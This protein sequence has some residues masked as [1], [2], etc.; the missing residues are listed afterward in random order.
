MNNLE[1]TVKDRMPAIIR[2]FKDSG[3]DAGNAYGASFVD[4]IKDS[5]N[6]FN[7]VVKSATDS[8]QAQLST[9]LKAAND[10]STAI[11]SLTEKV[12]N[13]ELNAVYPNIVME[14]DGRQIAKAAG[15]YMGTVLK[16][17]R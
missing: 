5:M 10:T 7:G 15:P 6:T 4:R 9:T 13:L 16:Y 3:T 11:D 12:S 2:L 17:K 1:N 8:A 14:S